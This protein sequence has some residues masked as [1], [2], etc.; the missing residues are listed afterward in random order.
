M[1]LQYIM[2]LSNKPNDNFIAKSENGNINFSCCQI[3]KLFAYQGINILIQKCP[4]TYL[5]FSHVVVT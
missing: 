5:T 1:N 3:F 2:L 4:P